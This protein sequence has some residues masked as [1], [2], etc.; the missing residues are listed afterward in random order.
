M[1]IVLN[2]LLLVVEFLFFFGAAAFAGLW[3]TSEFARGNENASLMGAT[4]ALVI[5]GIL[6]KTYVVSFRNQH[7]AFH[8]FFYVTLASCAVIGYLYGILFRWT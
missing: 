2:A 7:T 1:R 6:F 8:F 4:C 5:G 3:W